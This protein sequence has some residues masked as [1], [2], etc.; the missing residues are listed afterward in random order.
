MN[1]FDNNND[2]NNQNQG[3]PPKGSNFWKWIFAIGALILLYWVCRSIYAES[4]LNQY[5]EIFNKIYG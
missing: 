3:H 2:N 4:V 1:N 5:E